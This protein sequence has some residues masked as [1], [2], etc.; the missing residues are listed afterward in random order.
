MEVSS[1]AIVVRYL[2]IC[3]VLLFLVVVSM[4][5]V[6]GLADGLVWWIG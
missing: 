4:P 6:S 1:R 5:G 3:L 2:W